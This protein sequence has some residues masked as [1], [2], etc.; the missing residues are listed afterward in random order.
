MNHSLDVLGENIELEIH[1]IA[2]FRAVEIRVVP[3]VGDNPGDE[4]LWKNLS[5]RETDSVYRD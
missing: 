3:C 5:D 4:T 1:Q 2:W